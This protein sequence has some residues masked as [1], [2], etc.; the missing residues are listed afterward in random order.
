MRDFLANI[1]GIFLN[2][3]E[4]F[5]VI[6]FRDF[7]NDFFRD[8]GIWEFF[9]CFSSVDFWE[10]ISRRGNLRFGATRVKFWEKNFRKNL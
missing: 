10:R 2:F 9:C 1:A 4:N 8:F 6:F 7:L 5:C 3:F